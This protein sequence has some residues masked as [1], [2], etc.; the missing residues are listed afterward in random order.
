MATNVGLLSGWGWRLYCAPGQQGGRWMGRWMGGFDLEEHLR[1][2]NLIAQAYGLEDELVK[3]WI[4]NPETYPEEFKN[5]A[6]FLWKSTQDLVDGH[7]SVRYL[8]WDDG[9][10][11]V[12]WRWLGFDWY[13]RGPALLFDWYGRTPALLESTKN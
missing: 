9:R 5:K 12:R 1:K 2:N 6:V 10:V 3:G 11:V 13:G 7:R 4:A 8:N